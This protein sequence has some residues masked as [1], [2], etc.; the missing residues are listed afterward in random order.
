[1]RLELDVEQGYNFRK[2]VHKP[3]GFITKLKI[4]DKEFKVDQEINNIADDKPRK[5]VGIQGDFEW[6]MGVTDPV[7]F[8]FHVSPEN[9]QNI[10]LLKLGEMK[11]DQVEF[12]VE[13]FDF[14]SVKQ[15]FYPQFEN[16]KV[17]M[18]GVVMKSG[19][20]KFVLEVSPTPS[21]IVAKPENYYVRLGVNPVGKQVFHLASG[22]DKKVPKQWGMNA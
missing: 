2:D 17:V 5:V 22:V 14:D 4:G 18:K 7:I 10:D 21:S 9:K 11:K 20:G 19:D 3:C 13:L 15:Q 16:K 12:E 8:G 6:D 1:M